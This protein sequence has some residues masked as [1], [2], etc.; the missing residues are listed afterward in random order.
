V[1]DDREAIEP[2]PTQYSGKKQGRKMLYQQTAGG[3]DSSAKNNTNNSGY[4]TRIA[5]L[6]L[7]H[8]SLDGVTGI[9][10]SPPAESVVI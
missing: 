8:I 6:G 5:L 4:L 7:I 10:A 3:D 1:R 2:I 9:G